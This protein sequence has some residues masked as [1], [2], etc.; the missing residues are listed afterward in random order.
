MRTGTEVGGSLL[1]Q[2]DKGV[3]AAGVLARLAHETAD[4]AVPGSSHVAVD[5]GPTEMTQVAGAKENLPLDDVFYG[6][7]DVA[8]LGRHMPDVA[9][10]VETRDRFEW[11]GWAEHF[12][13][14]T[15]YTSVWGTLRPRRTGLVR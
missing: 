15:R 12:V 3:D 10:Q 6:A 14:T 13:Q 7:G 1:S 11:Y 2:S 4:V 8:P 5:G 9:D